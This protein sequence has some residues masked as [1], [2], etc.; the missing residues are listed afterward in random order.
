LGHVWTALWK[1]SLALLQHWSGA[2]ALRRLEPPKQHQNDDDDQNR[3]DE[4]DATVTVTV[5]VAAEAAAEAAEQE[6]DEDDYKNKP[7]RHGFIS[8][9]CLNE[10][11]SFSMEIEP[12]LK[13]I[14]SRQRQHPL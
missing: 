1:N 7:Q 4:P 13:P 9:C 3:A 12:W 6:D 5:A 2:V 10:I 8:V 11:Y 14:N